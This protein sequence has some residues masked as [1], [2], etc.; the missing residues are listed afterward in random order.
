MLIED[1]EI[2]QNFPIWSLFLTLECPSIILIILGTLLCFYSLFLNISTITFEKNSVN[3]NLLHSVYQVSWAFSSARNWTHHHNIISSPRKARCIYNPDLYPIVSTLRLQRFD[4]NWF[5]KSELW[6]DV[7]FIINKTCSKLV[8][9]I[10][11]SYIELNFIQRRCN[12]IKL[13]LPEVAVLWVCLR[14]LTLRSGVS[15]TF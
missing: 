1:R 8:V 4:S 15:G 12:C 3:E 11:I 5:F 14:V 2:Y 7:P 6:L 13:S 10:S 9:M